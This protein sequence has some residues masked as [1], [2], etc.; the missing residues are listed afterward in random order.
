MA[1][2]GHVVAWDTERPALGLAAV[3]ALGLMSVLGPRLL[4]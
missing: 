1:A 2:T 3:A 4:W